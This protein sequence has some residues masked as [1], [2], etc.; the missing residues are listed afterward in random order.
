MCAT[1][2]ARTSAWPSSVPYSSWLI[3]LNWVVGDGGGD[4]VG[5]GGGGGTVGSGCRGGQVVTYLAGAVALDL[6]LSQR[7][8]GE[9][10]LELVP[11]PE[12]YGLLRHRLVGRAWLR[13]RRNRLHVLAVESVLHG[14]VVVGVGGD[15]VRRG[16]YT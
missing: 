1:A 10:I 12:S 14:G 4:S 9:P 11:I 2:I 8:I 16:E 15:V 7:P 5:G 13:H 6:D 3:A